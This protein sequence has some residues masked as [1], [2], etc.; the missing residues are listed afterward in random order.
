MQGILG[1]VFLITTI[2]M[3]LIIKDKIV[4]N[5]FLIMIIYILQVVSW[6]GFISLSN[7][8][9][10]YKKGL[11]LFLLIGSCIILGFILLDNSLGATIQ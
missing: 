4:V 8:S 10:K 7:I 11:G 5:K 9:K 1:L 2:V 6:F 3:G